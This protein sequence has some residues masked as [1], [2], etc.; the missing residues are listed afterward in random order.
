MDTVIIKIYGLEKFRIERG[1]LFLPEFAT[2]RYDSLSLTERESIHPYLRRFSLRPNRRDEYL[3]G[4]EIFEAIGEDR[5]SLRYILQI[6]FSVPKLLYGNSLQEVV[7][8]DR[9]FV[10]SCLRTRLYGVGVEIE[11]NQ[12]ATALV[13]A[14]HFCKNVLLPK[15]IR[16]RDILK[17]MERVD[18]DKTVDVDIKEHKNGGRVLCIHSGTIERAFYDKISDALR[19]KNKRKDKNFIDPEREIVERFGLQDH[20][21]FRYE[22]R[23]KKTQTVMRDVSRALGKG[24]GPVSFSELFTPGLFKKMVL[25]SWRKLIERPE[26][27]LAL[28][29]P[30]DNL[31]L[32]LHIVAEA[33]KSG[34]TAHSLNKALISYGLARA[35]ADHGA[36]EVRGILLDGW[37]KDHP[38][39]LTDKIRTASELTRSIPYSNTMA[40]IDKALEEFI[41]ITIERL[42]KET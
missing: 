1:F 33:Q 40:F 32:L 30:E 19:P 17:E 20:E 27:R 2:R 9:D 26:N 18:I 36:K 10:F 5:R 7:E 37:C 42:A 38:E 41:P 23:I 11:I 12:I 39:R 31:K 3:P 24:Y 8:T 15:P 22:H 14:V 35:I 21:T 28:F 13:A 16:M 25:W 4:V 34:N 29:A 6:D